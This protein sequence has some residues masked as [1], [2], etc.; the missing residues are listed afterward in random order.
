M[1]GSFLI[2]L[3]SLIYGHELK[4]KSTFLQ[5]VTMNFQ[6]IRYLFI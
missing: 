6:N 1:F 3:N 5:V 2:K 4:L